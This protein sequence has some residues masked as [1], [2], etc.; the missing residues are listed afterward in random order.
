MTPYEN[1]KLNVH[2]L[3]TMNASQT[4]HPVIVETFPSVIAGPRDRRLGLSG[5]GIRWS[6]D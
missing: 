2:H 5:K 4:V 3:G 6:F 1:Q